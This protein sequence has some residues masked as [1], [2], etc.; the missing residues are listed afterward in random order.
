MSQTSFNFGRV[1]DRATIFGLPTERSKKFRSRQM[2]TLAPQSS[3]FS[4]HLL[5]NLQAKHLDEPITQQDLTKKEGRKLTLVFKE[6]FKSKFLN[7]NK[8]LTI[9]QP[10]LGESKNQETIDTSGTERKP[11][12][13]RPSKIKFP[14]VPQKSKSPSKADTSQASLQISQAPSLHIRHKSVVNSIR[15]RKQDS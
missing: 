13:F 9:S 2:S 1:K 5:D 7:L 3:N 4:S 6:S 12:E 8:D 10:S 15:S 11:I 14:A